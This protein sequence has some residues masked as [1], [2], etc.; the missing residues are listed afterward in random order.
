MHSVAWAN[1]DAAQMIPKLEHKYTLELAGIPLS[2]ISGLD[3]CGDHLLAIDDYSG[4][5]LFRIHYEADQPYVS[6]FRTISPPP[7]EVEAPFTRTWLAWKRRW[8]GKGFYDWEGL[9]CFEDDIYLVSELHG[10]VLKLSHED[11]VWVVEGFIDGTRNFDIYKTLDFD[12]ISIGYESLTV[13]GRDRILLGHEREP[14][15]LLSVEQG[16]LKL[17]STIEQ[18]QALKKLAEPTI[19]I[20]G[21][22][23]HEGLLYTL[24]RSA[25]A[26]C[27]R[28]I[29]DGISIGCGSYEHIEN[30]P[31]LRYE[32]KRFGRSEGIA[33]NADSIF[34]SL[35]HNS[36]KRENSDSDSS[37]IMVFKNPWTI[38]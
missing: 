12:R 31:A 25:R 33:V 28:S 37:V 18:D 21:S 11:T 34:I 5:D 38:M 23:M 7:L 36:D 10:A 3:F 35:D 26:V 17:L 30:I 32:D 6:K 14:S 29:D 15:L 2:G 16:R 20:T 8:G 27:V 22:D 13:T 4:S 1:D 9:S 24:H 19:D